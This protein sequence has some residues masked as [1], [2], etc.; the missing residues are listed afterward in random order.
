[1]YFPSFLSRFKS[2]PKVH[3][4]DDILSNIDEASKVN[5]SVFPYLQDSRFNQPYLKTDI[6]NCPSTIYESSTSPVTTCTPAT[7]SEGSGSPLL[8]PPSVSKTFIRLDL[9][10]FTPLVDELPDSWHSLKIEDVTQLRQKVR[11]LGDDNSRLRLALTRKRSQE[12]ILSEP[13]HP[14]RLHHDQPGAPINVIPIVRHS[15][16]SED[17]G[18]SSSPDDYDSAYSYYHNPDYFP[19]SSSAHPRART[20]SERAVTVFG[21][22]HR[23]RY[24]SL[25]TPKQL[26]EYAESRPKDGAKLELGPRLRELIS[27]RCSVPAA[28]DVDNKTPTPATKSSLTSKELVCNQLAPTWSLRQADNKLVRRPQSRLQLVIEVSFPFLIPG[29]RIDGVWLMDRYCNFGYFE[30]F[31]FHA[32]FGRWGPASLFSD[33]TNSSSSSELDYDLIEP[34]TESGDSQNEVEVS[35]IEGAPSNVDALFNNT[36]RQERDIYLPSNDAAAN[37]A[38][39]RRERHIA[40][41]DSIMEEEEEAPPG[42]IIVPTVTSSPSPRPVF[43][44]KMTQSALASIPEHDDRDT[45]ANAPDSTMSQ[46]PTLSEDRSS[47]RSPTLVEFEEGSRSLATFDDFEDLDFESIA[48][49]AGN[50]SKAVVPAMNSLS[51]GQVNTVPFPKPKDSTERM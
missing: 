20:E 42:A 47:T 1:M 14:R 29:Y 2:V 48:L 34:S 26:K 35:S 39:R 43:A 40:L 12:L 8:G 32:A 27:L 51:L 13:K 9:P 11:S 25:P 3:R 37:D 18:K 22:H 15:S 45:D 4:N 36:S 50:D 49:S 17:E 31:F 30:M 41:L 10:P 23:P 46:C 5:N 33:Q 44:L 16:S 7:T 19:A 21:A 24:Y 38:Q 28:Q 6:T